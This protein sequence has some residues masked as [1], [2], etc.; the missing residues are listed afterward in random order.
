MSQH[1]NSLG[2]PVGESVA[3]KPARPLPN[4]A[5][6]GR[7]CCVEPLDINRHAPDLFAAFSLDKTGANY[8][9]LSTDPFETEAELRDW[10]RES[11]AG[12]DPFFHSITVDGRAVGLASFMRIK[13]AEGVIEAGNI[14]FSPLLQRRPAATEAV[15]LMMARAFDELGYRR[16]EWKCDALNA[17]SRKAAARLGFTYEGLFR[18]ALVYKGRNR[19]TAWY[20]VI[21][22]EWPVIKAALE[23]WLSPD[24][25]D[26]GGTQKQ[27]LE[28]IRKSMA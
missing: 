6:Q 12:D 7:Y 19:D 15:Y 2:Q 20:S 18:Q 23:T 14:H 11:C 13:P 3:W 22:A 4:R 17:P 8:T 10:M 25:F 16:F 27:K 21:D 9:Y 26:K 1:L 5:M 24:N 28:S